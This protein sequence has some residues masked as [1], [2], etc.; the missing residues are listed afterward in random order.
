MFQ[1][2]RRQ[3]VSMPS[4]QNMSQGAKCFNTPILYT[5]PGCSFQAIF[6]CNITGT[7]KLALP[8]CVY[9]PNYSVKHISCFMLR[10][11]LTL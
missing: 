4:E 3:N 5:T 2:S 8:V 1:Y 9:F 10:Y 11:L 6:F 7:S